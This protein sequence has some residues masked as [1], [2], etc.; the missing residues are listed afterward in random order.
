MSAHGGVVKVA[1]PSAD[2]CLIAM[3]G[4]GVLRINNFLL[5]RSSHNG[6]PISKGSSKTSVKEKC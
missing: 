5:E 4:Y 2:D 6:Q 3:K 1:G